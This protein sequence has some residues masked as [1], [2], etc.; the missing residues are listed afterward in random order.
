MRVGV[1]SDPNS[2]PNEEGL[3]LVILMVRVPSR[4]LQSELSWR[5]SVSPST[6]IHTR[7]VYQ[8]DPQKVEIKKIHPSSSYTNIVQMCA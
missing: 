5:K 6:C 4:S 2:D 1:C 8:L 3:T 7:L